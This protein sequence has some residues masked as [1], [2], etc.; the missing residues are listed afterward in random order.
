MIAVIL[1]YT[2]L[3]DNS[4]KPVWGRWVE[5]IDRNKGISQW[6]P[7]I[8]PDEAIYLALEDAKLALLIGK[9]NNYLP[10]LQLIDTTNRIG[11]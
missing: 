6:R 2:M 8:A 9:V 11:T 3:K 4:R 7:M 5:C 10:R 1:I